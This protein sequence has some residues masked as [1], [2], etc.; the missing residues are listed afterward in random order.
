MKK[1]A[2]LLRSNIHLGP[3]CK[4]F[5]RIKTYF[6]NWKCQSYFG[7]HQKEEFKNYIN[8]FSLGNKDQKGTL[9]FK[10]HGRPILCFGAF[11]SEFITSNHNLPAHLS[12]KLGKNDQ[13]FFF[14]LQEKS[15]LFF[16]LERKFLEIQKVGK[17][18]NKSD[19]SHFHEGWRR[20]G[21]NTIVMYLN[22]RW[23]SLS[24][25]PYKMRDNSKNKLTICFLWYLNPNS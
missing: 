12:S 15:F 14:S 9:F 10:I 6:R 13:N 21:G 20:W 8:T 5:L 11:E 2:E 22:Y 3:E 7:V 24:I 17:I 18:C 4:Y 23:K 25:L 1:D 16:I 19:R